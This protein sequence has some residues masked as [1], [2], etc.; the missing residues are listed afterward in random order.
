MT[1]KKYNSLTKKAHNLVININ[2]IF[3]EECYIDCTSY[4]SDKLKEIQRYMDM[5]YCLLCNLEIGVSN[6]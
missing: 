6:D 3:R 5:V 2:K 4:N 1:K